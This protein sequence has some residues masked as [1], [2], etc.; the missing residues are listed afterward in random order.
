[1]PTKRTGGKMRTRV[2]RDG[3]FASLAEFVKDIYKDIPESMWFEAPPAEPELRSLFDAKMDAMSRSTVVDLV[4]FDGKDMVGE[5]E[6]V[7]TA[8]SLGYIGILVK[9]E[10]R[11]KGLASKLLDSAIGMAKGIGIDTVQ[12]EVADG[13]EAA[14]EFFIKHGFRQRGGAR[15]LKMGRQEFG[16][17]LMEKKV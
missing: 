6:I 4:T 17:L 11:R 8:R 9:K 10:Y 13:N 12:A 14:M 7:K 15:P 1:M 3:D 2:L 5:C 16:L